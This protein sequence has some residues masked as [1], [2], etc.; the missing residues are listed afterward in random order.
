MT[1]LS[2]QTFDAD[3]NIKTIKK[4]STGIEKG[5]LHEANGKLKAKAKITIEYGALTRED[6]T[7]MGNLMGAEAVVMTEGEVFN[8]MGT[9]PLNHIAEDARLAH[10]ISTAI[11][12]IGVTST[13]GSGNTIVCHPSLRDQV[14][15]CFDKMKDIEQFDPET[16]DMMTVQKPYFANGP[17]QVFETNVAP[18]DSVL[19]LYRGEGDDDQPLIYVEGEGLVMNNSLVS[20]DK[21]GKF[22]RIP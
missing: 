21:Y 1:F 11:A 7:P 12:N 3:G 17:L 8:T 22:V 10:R 18:D 19:V 14:D 13:R 15:A 4:K 20:V 9:P 5:S 2:E 16:E 6:L